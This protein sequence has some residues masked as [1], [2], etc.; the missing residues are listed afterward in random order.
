ML[1]YTLR[2]LEYFVTAAD[3]G[4]VARAAAELN[5]S[6]PSVSTAVAK[7][8]QQFGVQL[9]IRQ[10]AQGVLLTPPGR[11]ILDQARNLLRQARD[12][13]QTVGAAGDLVAG[14]IDIGCFTTLA[15]LFMPGLITDFTQRYPGTNVKLAEGIQDELL[16]GLLA[17]RFELALLYRLQ[18]P[19][20]IQVD[21]LA[22]T[23]P[24]VLLPRGHTLARRKRISLESLA[25]EPLI[26]LDVAPSRD[27]FTGIFR[28]HGLEPKIAF[29]SPS[30]E[31]VRGLV[32]RGQGYS[33]LVT[34]PHGDHTYDGQ[35]LVI[36]PIVE[37][38]LP[39]EICL[40]RPRRSK[41]T[42]LTQAFAGFCTGWFAEARVGD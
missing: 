42:R 13:Q 10:H 27:Y 12:L 19:D 26:L 30:M 18:I 38:C 7:L 2:Q 20:E 39:G 15:P 40:A 35:D 25:R 6:Q 9:F 5:V 8:E 1:K 33:I 17:G 36:R 3:R 34:R 16:A 31:M 41:P 23:D 29:S 21:T 4:S 37:P 24:Y 11:R 32:G 28:A 14:E 22:R